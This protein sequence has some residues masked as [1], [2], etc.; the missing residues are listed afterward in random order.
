MVFWTAGYFLQNVGVI[1]FC[2]HCGG[3]YEFHL[4]SK[5]DWYEVF[6]Y[7]AS[8]NKQKKQSH[9]APWCIAYSLQ[10]QIYS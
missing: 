2:P 7:V 3:L 5:S 10:T 4:D 6:V 8:K 9:L 1:F